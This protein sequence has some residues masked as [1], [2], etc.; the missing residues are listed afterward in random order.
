MKITK[1]RAIYFSGTGNTGRC[2]AALAE[3]L[4][5]TLEVPYEMVSIAPQVARL[6]DFTFSEEELAIVA[7]PTY[8]GRV[9]KFLLPF[10][11]TKIQGAKTPAIALCTYGNQDFGNTLIE[12][13]ELLASKDFVTISAG[14][15][16]S[17]HV[18]APE[19]GARRPNP[20]DMQRVYNLAKFTADK[21]G[22][23]DSLPTEPLK[24][25]GTLPLGPYV[26]PRDR[27]GYPVNISKSRPK[28]APE[29]KK[30]APACAKVCPVGAI[31][32]DG[33]Q[34]PGPCIR[35][36]FC[37]KVSP[38]GAKFYG[39]DNMIAYRKE[40]VAGFTKPK[41]SWIFG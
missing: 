15:I 26:T 35:C 24:V 25:P 41:K 28:T 32:P 3:Q 22:K 38:V 9:P 14:A 17:Q 27:Y 10:F 33:I 7:V 13:R 31:A 39:D 20:M 34:I 40:L 6:K 12:M 36:G 18:L 5:K 37:I 1:I 23:L 8:D 30:T 21:L 11:E 16:V 29:H 4:G 19:V 2:V